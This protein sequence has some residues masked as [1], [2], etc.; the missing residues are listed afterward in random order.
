MSQ[1]KFAVWKK[2]NNNPYLFINLVFAIFP[3]SF[4]LGSLIVN[5]NFLLFCCLGINYLK[6]KILTTKFDFILKIIFI[7]FFIIF[8]STLLTLLKSIYF[9]EYLSSNLTKLVNSLLFFRFFLR[10]QISEIINIVL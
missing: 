1:T 7:F 2:I 6:A 4:I 5:L 3:I 8:F 10:F 9:D